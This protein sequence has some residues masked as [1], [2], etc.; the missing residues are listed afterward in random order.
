MASRAAASRT[1]YELSIEV[2]IYDETMP[3]MA[4]EAFSRMPRGSIEMLAFGGAA[5]SPTASRRVSEMTGESKRS[6]RGQIGAL[7]ACHSLRGSFSPRAGMTKGIG[8][9]SRLALLLSV[10]LSYILKR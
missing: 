6:S 5:L 10:N 4:Q 2:P 8:S 1:R 3:L 7:H 9:R